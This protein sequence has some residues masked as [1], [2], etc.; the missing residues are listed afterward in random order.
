MIL[1]IAA[2]P[3][4]LARDAAE[5]FAATAEDAARLRGRF[6]VALAG[7]STPRG[8]Y[9]LLA[10]ETA[11]RLR[12][13]WTRTHAFWGDERCV[14][15]DH[16]ESNYRMAYDA[17]L[18]HV[19]VPDSSVHRMEG[20]RPDAADAAAA[21][22]RVLKEH[23]LTGAGGG[24]LFDL[25]LLGMGDDG[26]TASLFPGS[27]ALNATDRLVAAPWVDALGAH[28]ITLTVRA[29]CDA[30]HVLFLVAGAGKAATL[31]AVL[32]EGPTD[33]LPASLIR[34]EK[35]RLTWLVDQDAA[36]LLH[37]RASPEEAEG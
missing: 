30:G 34:P 33:R 17:M 8:L 2:D 36:R 22:E 21:Y 35:G 31:R 23:R 13:P 24:P 14:P 29:L 25:V 5:I 19:D 6:T 26:H 3:H 7:G 32:E 10:G 1:N 20:E 28:R 12:V 9:A 27:D 15:P 11:F 16:P 18:S 37:A 4:A